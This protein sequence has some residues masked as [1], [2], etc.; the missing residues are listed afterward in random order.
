MVAQPISC[1]QDPAVL[2]TVAKD[3]VTYGCHVL[4]H[5]WLVLLMLT[6][7]KIC[8]FSNVSFWTSSPQHFNYL[9]LRFFWSD[10]RQVKSSSP[11]EGA[12]GIHCNQTVMEVFFFLLQQKVCWKLGVSPGS[13]SVTKSA[14]LVMFFTT[15]FCCFQS[16]N[17]CWMHFCTSMDLFASWTSWEKINS[18]GRL[19]RNHS[20]IRSFLYINFAPKWGK[21]KRLKNQW[22][23][24]EN[25]FTKISHQFTRF[26]SL[27]PICVAAWFEWSQS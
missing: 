7:F 19:G 1:S 26:T 25:Q 21:Q 10:Q 8:S 11:H 2:E 16:L 3:P 23:S 22:Q 15:T 17:I 9:H 6:Y 4:Y 12:L 24:V 27:C 20:W 14:K 13:S 18:G 5:Y